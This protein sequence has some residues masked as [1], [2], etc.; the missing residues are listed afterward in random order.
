[1]VLLGVIAIVGLF[2]WIGSKPEAG[3][4]LANEME[5]YA[6]S[7]I[8]KQQLLEPGETLL[9]YYDATMSMDGSEAAILTDRRVLYH[10]SGRTTALALKDVERIDHREEGLAGDVFEIHGTTGT[11]I[12]I[13]IAPLNQGATFKNV[14]DAAWNKARAG[15]PPPEE[16]AP[17]PAPEPAPAP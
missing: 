5:P 12:K 8:E 6:L 7:Y 10:K 11:A 17:A 2:V 1:M 3:V 9:A 13:E 15:G 16:P 4:K 14:L